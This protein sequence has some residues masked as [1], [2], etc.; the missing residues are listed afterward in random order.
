MSDL[1]TYLPHLEPLKADQEKM[2]QCLETWANIN[3]GTFNIEGIAK[4]GAVLEKAFSV[5]PAAI[6][7]VPLKTET[8]N[9]G[10][11]LRVRCR[12]EAK[13]QI[14]LGGH[15]DTV[16]GKDHSFQKC[17][18]IEEGKMRGP[19][20]AD[21]KGGILVMLEALK[22]FEETP[23]AKNV[24][25]EVFINTEE[26][27]GSPAA[28]DYFKEVAN[29]F[30][31]GLVFEPALPGGALVRNRL[32]SGYFSAKVTGRAAHVG[33]H[34]TQ[35]RNAI[36]HLSAFIGSLYGL[37]REFPEVIIN[38]G[39]IEGGGP[40]N[41]VPELA[42]AD[43]NVRI[44]NK[45]QGDALIA[46]VSKLIQLVNETEGIELSWNGSF[47]RP[48]KVVDEAIEN[49]FHGYQNCG[50]L[51]DLSLNW[52]DT[53]GGCDG[54]N[55]ADAGLPNL[56]SLGVCGGN[57][58]SKDEFVVLGSLAERAQL[59]ALFLMKLANNDLVGAP[60]FLKTK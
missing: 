9:F 8:E 13:I 1:E 39:R 26:E 10:E 11:A 52:G 22:A 32:G 60:L 58:H 46:A 42:S 23:W 36:V 31:F 33:R 48:P 54:S 2:V 18:R 51:L 45:E 43:F 12:P 14:F 44:Q 6:D 20:V 3:S 41:V 7:R 53:G 4:M 21:M 25:W 55:L 24:G 38:V 59:T 49:L 34:Y 28:G 40:L 27:I 37:K 16:Y 15:M 30:S 17:E 47:S 50:Q 57:L 56:D 5:L 29:R 19:G 35:G